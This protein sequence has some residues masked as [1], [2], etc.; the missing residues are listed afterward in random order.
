MTNE[1]HQTL[2]D[3]KVIDDH[4]ETVGTVTD[5]LYD[6]E[7]A[8]EPRWAIVKTGMIAGERPAPLEG[9]YVADSGDLV[10]PFDRTTIKHAPKIPRDHVLTRQDEVEIAEYYDVAK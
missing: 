2:T 10:V 3:R 1:S 6:S 4:F 8:M 5:V 7:Q 9:A